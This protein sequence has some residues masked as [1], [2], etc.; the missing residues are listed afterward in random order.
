M[1][2]PVIDIRDVAK[3]FTLHNQGGAVLRV[4]EGASLSVRAGECVGLTGA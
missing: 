1:T 2:D 4:M 3:T